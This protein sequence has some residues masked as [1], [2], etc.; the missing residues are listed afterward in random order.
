MKIVSIRFYLR[1]FTFRRP[2]ETLCKHEIYFRASRC[3]REPF[4]IRS[5]HILYAGRARLCVYICVPP[6]SGHTRH[7]NGRT[8]PHTWDTF[9]PHFILA[10]LVVE[11]I[12][13]ADRR[14]LLLLLLWQMR[15]THFEISP[16]IKGQTRKYAHDSATT[17]LFWFSF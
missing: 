4:I 14:L 1:V 5:T 6:T 13:Y 7:P 11:T 15:C 2:S 8:K 17:H 10:M 9:I 12:A 3:A 16:F